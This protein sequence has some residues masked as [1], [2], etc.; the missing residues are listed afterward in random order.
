MDIKVHKDAIHELSYKSFDKL[1]VEQVGLKTQMYYNF[2]ITRH[3]FERVVSAFRNKL[4]KPFGTWFQTTYGS[5]ILRKFRK[6][7][8]A[9]EY[10]KGKGVTF[11]EFVDYIIQTPMSQLDEHWRWQYGLCNICGVKYDYIADMSTLYEDSD[12]ILRAIGWYDKVQFPAKSK[13][14]YK[15][16]AVDLTPEYLNK[17]SDEQLNSLYSRYQYD[18]LAFGY[19]F[20]LERIR[21]GK[22]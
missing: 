9:Q 20:N 18:F 6:N 13:D 8:T 16:A 7:L 2:I 5:V 12:N 22:L 3:P 19:E 4:E 10:K 15:K 1:S 11:P 17:L 21:S 14:S